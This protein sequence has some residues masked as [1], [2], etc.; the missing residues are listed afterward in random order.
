LLP[1][2]ASPTPAFWHR[3]CGIA[4][5]GL[6]EIYFCSGLPHFEQNDRSSGMLISPLSGKSLNV[7]LSATEST[8]VEPNVPAQTENPRVSIGT[9]AQLP[10]S[11]DRRLTRPVTDG[12][13][14][15]QALEGVVA[16]WWRELLTLDE[17]NLDDDFF[18]LGG[19][20]LVGAQ[21][22]SRIKDAYGIDFGLST[23][24]DARTVRALAQLIFE[25]CESSAV[26]SK[27]WCTLVP[28]KPEGTRRPLI[29]I[30]GGNGTSVL[31]FK[32]VSL[33]LGDDQP[34]Y[35]LEAKMPEPDEEFESIPERA[36]RFIVEVRS[37]QPQGPYFLIG[38]CGGGYVAFEMAQQLSAAGQQVAFLG[39]VECADDRHP[40]SLPGRTRFRIERAAWRV[41][42]LLARGAR[43][44]A[45]FA[46][47]RFRSMVQMMHLHIQRLVARSLSKPIPPLPLPP[48][49]P[50]EKARRIVDR[51]QPTSYTGRSYVVIGRDTYQYC[52]LSCTVDPRLVW[53]KLSE[54]GSEVKTIPGDHTDMLEAPIVYEF[55]RELKTSLE[56]AT[57]HS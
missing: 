26:E 17:V 14:S 31:L 13:L 11:Q 3:N 6:V 52:G 34:A 49:D 41:Q 38:F 4:G 46:K 15:L 29:W 12:T 16:A 56:R 36:R 19:H 48:V 39:I 50:Y 55:A 27:P 54:G 7:N 20:S 47:E 53:C 2:R 40:A 9:D 8:M 28:I 35:G 57:A 32:E 43:G 37:L 22:F 21:L 33:L 44:M 10:Q 51:Y 25:R 24:F 45:L 5:D 30:P 23:L 18:E 42:K 1:I